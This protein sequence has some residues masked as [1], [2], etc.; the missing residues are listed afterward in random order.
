M[1]TNGSLWFE[2]V[3]V[4]GIYVHKCTG[5]KRYIK[6]KTKRPSPSLFRMLAHAFL[7][8][9]KKESWKK[10]LFSRTP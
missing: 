3:N 9:V 7:A 1:S 6:I 2:M 8:I 4:L 5:L 10:S